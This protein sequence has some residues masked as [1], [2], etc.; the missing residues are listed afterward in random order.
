MIIS[1]WGA[2]CP[3]FFCPREAFVQGAFVRGLMSVGLCPVP[4]LMLYYTTG[5]GHAYRSGTPEYNP[6]F[7]RIS[8]SVQC[9]I[10]HCLFFLAIV[11]SVL[12]RFMAS[13]YSFCNSKLF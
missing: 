5:A 1:L 7:G 11:L 9:F 2:F 12:H 6:L 8:F 10:D 13:N 3:G 4:E